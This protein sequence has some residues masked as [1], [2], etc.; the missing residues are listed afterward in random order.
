MAQVIAQTIVSFIPS[1]LG[2]NNYQA[3]QW[4]ANAPLANFIYV[5][6][7]ES[8]IIGLVVWF[9]RFKKSTMQEAISL[10]RPKWLDGKAAILGFLCYIVIYAAV[11]IV[12]GELVPINTSQEQ[13]VGFAHTVR[14]VGL[15]MAFISLVIL[16]PI[17]EESVF[18]GFL[19]GTLRRRN[20]SFLWSTIAVSAVFGSMHLFGG[21]GGSLIWVAFLDTFVL[22]LALCYLREK[23]GSIWASMGVHALKNAIVFVNL[24]IISSR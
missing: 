15:I 2:W 23:T 8:L 5:L 20:V 6:L 24:F 13:A 3:A 4:V 12:V 19:Y 7:A 22:S 9:I 21:S 17:V 10:R 18:R 1:I 11:L 14:G 16:P